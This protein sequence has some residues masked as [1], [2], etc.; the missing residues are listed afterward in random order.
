MWQN[1]R[2]ILPYDNLPDIKPPY[3]NLPDIRPPYDKTP[4]FNLPWN[5][6]PDNKLPAY[7]SAV[8]KTPGNINARWLKATINKKQLFLFLVQQAGEG[9]WGLWVLNTQVP[10]TLRHVVKYT[11]RHVMLQRCQ[12]M[13]YGFF[14]TLNL[15]FFHPKRNNEVGG[16]VTYLYKICTK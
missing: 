1:A 10:S 3:Y 13:Q 2:F 6:I 14:R 11:Y 8:W 9:R 12:K 5:K 15:N 4:D 7:L 16:K